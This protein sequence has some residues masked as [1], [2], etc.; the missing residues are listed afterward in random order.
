M[1]N[2]KVLVVDDE[3]LV[4]KSLLKI[5]KR[6][7]IIGD[8]AEDGLVAVEMSKKIRY[9][10]I[11]CDIRMPGIDGIETIK[12]IKEKNPEIK[13]IIMTG[14]ANNETPVRAIRLGVNDY[15]YKPFELEEF[16]ICLMRN[17]NLI[18][19]EEKNRNLEYENIKH[20]QMVAIGSMTNSI[21]HDVK[22]ALTT[23]M[24]FTGIIRQEKLDREKEEKFLDLI[25]SQTKSIGEKL[26]D[27]L[28]FSRGEISFE[29]ERIKVKDI[30]KK[31]IKENRDVLN[32]KEI[33]LKTE[34][35]N[36]LEESYLELDER[37][38]VQVFYNLM[39][40]SQDA[41]EKR[42]EK[43]IEMKFI[44]KKKELLILFKDN[45]KGIDKEKIDKIFEP[46]ETFGK[47]NGT[48]LGLAIVKKVIESFGGKMEVES[49]KNSFTEFKVY[50]K[51]A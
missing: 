5:L 2:L 36:E 45:G 40:N 48:G 22:N 20:Q 28:E 17:I 37:K 43:R 13:T 11:I 24:G 7:G 21:V 18:K 46:F 34:F 42:I 9:D 10:I 49:E 8:G 38:I 29:L 6:D 33:E 44:K 41:L 51:L 50:L 25:L 23:I 4:R 1:E 39:T 47:K 12:R 27:I 30:F 26:Q 15:I 3:E 14:Y 35:D 31:I 19:L 32:S 16:R